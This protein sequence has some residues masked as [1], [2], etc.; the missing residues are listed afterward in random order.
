MTGISSC[1]GS[2]MQA[3]HDGRNMWFVTLCSD[4]VQWINVYASMGDPKALFSN[5]RACLVRCAPETV[6]TA[7]D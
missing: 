3:A 2:M 7:R 5:C 6:Y 4:A 1:L